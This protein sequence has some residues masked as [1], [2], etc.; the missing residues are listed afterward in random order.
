MSYPYK[1]RRTATS[2]LAGDFDPRPQRDVLT[3][4]LNGVSMP[5][6]TEEE[7]NARRERKREKK[8]KERRE[9][10]REK[11]K[12][13]KKRVKAASKA[14]EAVAAPIPSTSGTPATSSAIAPLKSASI[15]APRATTSSFWQ[16]RPQIVIPYLQRSA[17][18]SPPPMPSSPPT[19]PGPSVSSRTSAVSSKRPFTPDDDDELPGRQQSMESDGSM[20]K[21][22]RKKRPAARKGW[23]GW[24]EGSPP[25]S[26]KLI[27]LDSVTVL[28]ERKTRSGKS[29]DAIGAG[30]DGWV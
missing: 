18:F 27:N 1:R 19:T 6:P 28:A 9:R 8:E 17:S 13:E 7:L 15:A 25:P 24:V 2:V 22:P 23:K 26:D 30:R 21:R 20:H 3:S 5:K 14:P 16:A 29:F 10:E 11:E 12:T 4:L